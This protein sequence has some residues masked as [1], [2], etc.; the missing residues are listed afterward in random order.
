MKT[1]DGDKTPGRNVRK[2]RL[3]FLS[4]SIDVRVD[5]GN[6]IGRSLATQ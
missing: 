1:E 4:Y 5:T 3:G 6:G 2:V